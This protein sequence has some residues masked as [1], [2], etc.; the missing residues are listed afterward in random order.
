MPNVSF[1]KIEIIEFPCTVG[2]GPAEGTPVQLDWVPIDRSEFA[3]NFFEFYR[4][5]RRRKHALRLTPERRKRLLLRTGHSLSDIATGEL[6]ALTLRRQRAQAIR[7]QKRIYKLQKL[8]Q[9]EKPTTK[10]IIVRP[11]TTICLSVP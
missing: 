9:M 5:P 4:P 2:D 7:W 10:R 11:V 8:R 1:D 6:Q 3:I